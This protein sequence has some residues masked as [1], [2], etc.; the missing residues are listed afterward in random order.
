MSSFSR[1]VPVELCTYANES[2][3]LAL[4]QNLWANGRSSREEQ[5]TLQ[6]RASLQDL[7]A[8]CRCRR[9]GFITATCTE[10]RVG[11]WCHLNVR[12]IKY[13]MAR[14]FLGADTCPAIVLASKSGR[15]VLSLTAPSISRFT[16]RCRSGGPRRPA[17]LGVVASCV[18]LPG[19]EFHHFL[20]VLTCDSMQSPTK[21]GTRQGL[22]ACL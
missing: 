20:I 9:P 8:D 11:N 6:A 15:V 13:S 3:R 4:Q 21:I 5:P 22:I 2:L 14:G 1:Q 16:F 18:G 17:E 7:A 10:I 12:W 19:D